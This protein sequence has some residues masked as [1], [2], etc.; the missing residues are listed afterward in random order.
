[1]TFQ[2]DV[3]DSS[4]DIDDLSK[5]ID[6]SSKDVDDSLK[7]VDDS[8]EDVHDFLKDIDDFSGVIDV[9]F[10]DLDAKFARRPPCTADQ[11]ETP[12]SPDWPR[13]T[14][15]VP[16][17]EERMMYQVPTPSLNTQMSALPSPS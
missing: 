5:D 11:R 3:D 15:P 17:S 10:E 7:G 9:F 8:F 1:M 6:D 4:K 14:I 13:E 12:M 2:K 16:P